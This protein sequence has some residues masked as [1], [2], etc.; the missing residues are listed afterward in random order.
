MAVTNFV[1]DIWSARVLMNLSRISVGAGICNRDYE[2][3]IQKSGDSVQITSFTDPAISDYTAHSDLTIEAVTDANRAL[4]INQAK[5]FAFEVDD[6]EKAQSV[7]GGKVLN[8]QIM[9]ASYGLA[10]VLDTTV[11]SAIG[12][13][14]S[15]SAPDHQIAEATIS[16]ASDA[17]N[18]L[19]DWSV[20]LDE[21]DVPEMDRWSVVSPA[22][23]GLI[24]KDARFVGAGDA[25]GAT[26]R[27][28]GRVGQ[29][30]GFEIFKS[31]NL[32][33]GPGAGAGTS[34]LAGS[35]S[36]TTLA[37]QVASVES[38]RM[39]KRFNDAVKG[40]HLYGVK[41][42]RDASIVSADIIVG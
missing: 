20:L 35:R 17:Y 10:N 2:G 9:R 37:E 36:A 42:T 7:D 26:T 3:D 38:F 40:L 21:A 39:E 5:S 28:N 13:G 22:F 19:V 14:A 30:A 6:V 24:L 12:T 27:A 41:V 16:T 25:A 8:T 29:A 15:A 4:L 34:M 1:P 31:N 23:Y 33:D 11:L 18:A 32:P